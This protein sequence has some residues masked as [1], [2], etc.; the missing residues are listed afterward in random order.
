MHGNLTDQ[1]RACALRCRHTHRFILV[2]IT[3]LP[4]AFWSLFG[5]FTLPI[6]AVFTF[7]LCGVENVGVQIEE[8]HRVLPLNQICASGLRALRFMMADHQGA[9]G[10]ASVEGIAQL[11]AGF[12]GLRAAEVPVELVGRP[13][14][15][16]AAA[17]QQH[18][19]AV[20]ASN[21]GPPASAVVAATAGGLRWS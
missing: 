7:L 4:F 20:A 18:P 15:G 16:S 11:S 5:W 3:F 9:A 17:Q 6:M 13:G 19:A 10:A 1:L 21:G 14:G 2:Y 8:P 12:G